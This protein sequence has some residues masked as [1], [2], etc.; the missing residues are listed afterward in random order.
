MFNKSFL[1]VALSLFAS[2]AAAAQG[3]QQTIKRS[4]LAAKVDAGF[5][6]SDTNHDGSLS[7]AELQ[8]EQNKELQEVKNQL[9][10]K[11]RAAFNQL[12]TNK[13]GQ[14][15]FQEFAASVP[16]VKANET[17]AQVLQKLDTNHDGKVSAAEFRAP[18]LAAFDKV[19]LN[20]DGVVTQDEA[21]RAQGQK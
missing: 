11:L 18:R 8:A 21:R 5:A 6:A 20:H 7:V 9:Q 1:G 19:D 13:D 17:P 16:S 4:D 2:T 3:A 12:D 15:S 14:L 10:N